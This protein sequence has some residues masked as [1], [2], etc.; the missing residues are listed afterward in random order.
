[1]DVEKSFSSS[2][3]KT[4]KCCSTALYIRMALNEIES[5]SNILIYNDELIIGN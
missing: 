1:M 4:H 3:G 2:K 5:T